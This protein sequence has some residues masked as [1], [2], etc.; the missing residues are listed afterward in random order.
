M[1]PD[2]EAREAAAREIETRTLGE[3]PM[4]SCVVLANAAIDAYLAALS[5]PNEGEKE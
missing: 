1:T 2:H 3:E 4:W 5:A